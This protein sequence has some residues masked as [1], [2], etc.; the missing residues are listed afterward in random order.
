MN[1]MRFVITTII[2]VMSVCVLK[3][4]P[5]AEIDVKKPKK[6]ENRKLPSEKTGEKKFTFQRKNI[7][8]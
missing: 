1:K 7:I 2:T 6:Y 5:G 3:A 4:Q 8:M